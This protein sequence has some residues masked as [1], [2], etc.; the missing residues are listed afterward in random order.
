MA[1]HGTG[2]GFTVPAE[3]VVS[4]SHVHDPGCTWS[5]RGGEQERSSC[6]LQFNPYFSA[7]ETEARLQATQQTRAPI[8]TYS[9]FS[10]LTSVAVINLI[11]G[12]F[13]VQLHLPGYC[14]PESDSR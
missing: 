8:G 11:L 6:I 4:C 13:K 7:E 10:R 12:F 9:V 3:K 1:A 5:S 14:P 2:G